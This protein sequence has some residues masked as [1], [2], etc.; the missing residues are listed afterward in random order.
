MMLLPFAVVE[1]TAVALL[2]AVVG[3]VVFFVATF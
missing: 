2:P 3:L 1:V